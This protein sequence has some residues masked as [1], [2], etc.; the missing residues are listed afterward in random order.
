MR[1]MLQNWTLRLSKLCRSTRKKG[2]T[3]KKYTFYTTML[4]VK[5]W[6]IKFIIDTGSQVTLLMSK[7]ENATAIKPVIV[8][9]RDVN[10]NRNKSRVKQ[11]PRRYKAAIGVTDNNKS[12]RKLLG[13]DWMG[14]LGITLGKHKVNENM[15]H[16]SNPENIIDR[17]IT[18]LERK[19][20]K[21]F[22]ESQT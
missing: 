1:K 4:L 17:N 14:R 3:A 11:Q 5:H 9:Y 7:L 19:I 12:T 10:D 8:E 18:T 13:I 6:P 22:T 15:N 16:I 21:F 20:N 2:H